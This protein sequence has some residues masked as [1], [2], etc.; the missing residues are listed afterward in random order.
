MSAT[1]LAWLGFLLALGV[2]CGFTGRRARATFNPPRHRPLI[3]L[4]GGAFLLAATFV[5]ALMAASSIMDGHIHL[6]RR[7]ITYA[8]VSRATDP[9]T[10][11]AAIAVVYA[12]MLLLASYAVAVLGLCVRR[13]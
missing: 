10:F 9:M 4:M 5:L 2:S 11:W 7:T 1:S 8:N 13:S 12:G 3:F 6:H